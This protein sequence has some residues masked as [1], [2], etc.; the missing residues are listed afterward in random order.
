MESKV[1]HTVTSQ[2]RVSRFRSNIFRECFF[3]V[4]LCYVSILQ[5]KLKLFS[6]KRIMIMDFAIDPSGLVYILFI[7]KP[8]L[9]TKTLE[10]SN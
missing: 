9:S 7:V 8:G 1:C 4:Y 10:L 5:L 6:A 3:L 2:A